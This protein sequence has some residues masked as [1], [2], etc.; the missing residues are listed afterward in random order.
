M[1]TPG[2]EKKK[3]LQLIDKIRGLP[4]LCP[5]AE[6]VAQTTLLETLFILGALLWKKKKTFSNI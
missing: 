6:N 4:V 3:R 2:A 1:Q 5:L